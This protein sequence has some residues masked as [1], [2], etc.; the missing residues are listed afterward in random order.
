[1]I[2]RAVRDIVFRTARICMEACFY[3][4]MLAG[5]CRMLSILGTLLW[6]Y[7]T[8]ISLLLSCFFYMTGLYGALIP[9]Q[10]LKCSN[11][12]LILRKVS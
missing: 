12:W 2:L 5:K 8:L 10:K 4:G 6:K 7:S 9:S 11:L 1:M 3:D